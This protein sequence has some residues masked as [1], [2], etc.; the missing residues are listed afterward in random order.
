MLGYLVM[1]TEASAVTLVPAA[2][3]YLS[4][5]IFSI[6]KMVKQFSLAAVMLMVPIAPLVI[7]I[8][9]ISLI[10]VLQAIG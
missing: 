4:A 3:V 5:V 1:H 10:H 2:I 9:V 8:I 7:L 6:Y